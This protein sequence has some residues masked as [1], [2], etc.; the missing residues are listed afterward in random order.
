[1][2]FVA[3]P[4][5]V[6]IPR[7]HAVWR[8]VSHC[9]RTQTGRKVGKVVLAAAILGVGLKLYKKYKA[10]Q[11]RQR[12]SQAGKD[13]VVLHQF[14]RGTNMPNLSPFALKLETYLRMAGIKYIV[15]TEE[16][17][18]ARGKCPWITINGEELSD[19]EL[20]ID[21]L[22]KHF[23]KPI[24]EELSP[25]QHAIGR[26]VQ[27]MLDEHTIVAVAYK[28][29]VLDRMSYILKCFPKQY[30]LMM[31]I[32]YPAFSKQL[33]KYFF[34]NGMGRF[35]EEEVL[36]FL[37]RELRALEDVIGD[38][39]FVVAKTPSTY[40]AAVFA[41]L[42]QVII[43]CAPE[44]ERYVRDNHAVLVQYFERMKDK[45]WPDWDQ[46]LSQ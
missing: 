4:G 29:Y 9:A 26:A 18:G 10:H 19:S 45:Y 32:F 44:V 36:F 43:G 27:V 13:V 46:C 25:S 22:A 1:M 15:D 42:T 34:T 41:E 31:R 28:R 14:E 17:Q 5:G 20:I 6:A 38:K 3:T 37:R 33:K 11:R 30:Q 40:D 35:S 21:Y 7:P 8:E 16:P 39:Q 12:W 23:N 2:A 24:K